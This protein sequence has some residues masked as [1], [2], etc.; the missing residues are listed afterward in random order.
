MS[1]E[2]ETLA[3]LDDFADDT[4][5]LEGRPVDV[6]VDT[7]VDVISGDGNVR[8]YAAMVTAKKSSFPTWQS[9]DELFA[10]IG[11]F[12]LRDLIADDGFVLS[13][14]ATKAT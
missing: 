1:I 7:D 5:V 13:I 6:I 4:A 8:R 2:T 14:S 3:A 10:A 9:G 12:H 11:N